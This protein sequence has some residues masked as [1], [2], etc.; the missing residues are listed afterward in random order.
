MRGGRNW[1]RS[2]GIVRRPV[3]RPG[4]PTLGSVGQERDAR[5]VER[6]PHRGA[7]GRE[8]GG[9]KVGLERRRAG[10]SI[11]SR[12]RAPAKV[13]AT[14]VP[15]S[16]PSASSRTASGRMSA[17]RADAV[18]RAEVAPGARAPVRPSTVTSMRLVKPS[19]SA[20]RERRRCA[21]TP[22]AATPVW[23]DAA[24]VEEHEPV[25]QRER[26]GVVVGDGDDREVEA[27]EQRAG[28]RT[29]SRSRRGRSSEPRGSSSRRTRGRGRQRAGQRDPLLLAARERGD[30]AALGALRGRPARAARRP[31]PST[32]APRCPC[33]RSPK[34]TL[35]P[36][37]RCGNRAWCWNI[38]PTPR[39][40]GGVAVA[41]APSMRHAPGVE[42]AAARRWRAAGSTCRCRSD[43]APPPPRRR[44]RRGRR[45]RGR[46]GARTRRARRSPRRAGVT[47]TRS[48]RRRADASDP[49]AARPRW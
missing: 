44:R 31:A 48:R 3:R 11:R 41:S 35:A 46:R 15:S 13:P 9:R 38:I 39:R 19:S 43:R 23:S 1:S 47:P 40:C 32:A 4:R 10:T 17:R 45:R 2:G 33:I 26:L 28:A 21:A 25:G 6:H 24:A 18:G 30:V 37:S 16:G 20:T 36:T 14:T 42:R 8:I 29:T 5:R 27:G 7:H 12:P 34:A 22:R 49:R